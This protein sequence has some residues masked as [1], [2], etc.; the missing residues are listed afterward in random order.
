VLF[1]ISLPAAWQYVA[2]MKRERSAYLHIPFDYLYSIYVI[3]VLASIC[4]H[5]VLVW[6]AIRGRGEPSGDPSA[7][8]TEHM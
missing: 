8:S 7:A 1:V 5:G 2:F 3:F 4:R 6:N